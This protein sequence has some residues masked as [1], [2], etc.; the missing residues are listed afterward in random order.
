MKIMQ[1]NCV[2]RVG[3]TGKIVYDIHN[4]LCDRGIESVVCYGRGSAEFTSENGVYKTCS[5]HYADVNHLLARVSGVMY[6]GCT[7]STKKLINIIKKEKPDIVH[8]HCINGYFV[9][10][11]SI[12]RWLG[13]N[14]IKTLVTMHAEFF[15]TGG[16]GYTY[17]CEK[18][19][20]E[21]G[22]SSCPRY[23]SETESILFDR[24]STMWKRM[25]KA[26]SYFDEDNLIVTSVSPWLMGRGKQ[27][28]ILKDKKHET[29]LNGTDTE[30]VFVPS[31]FDELKNKLGVNDEKI[32]LHVTP[33][34]NTDPNH[35]KGG[36]YVTELAKKMAD[37]PVRFIVVGNC[38][39]S[40][41]GFPDNMTF[42]G[43]VSD[44]QTLAQY[45][46]MADVTLLTSKRE[47][48]SMICAESLACGT[49]VVGFE[50]GAPEGI[51]IKEYSDFVSYGDLEQLQNAV[52]KRLSQPKPDAIRNEA[53]VK[54][55]R[56]SMV[57]NYIKLYKSMI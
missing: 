37:K 31:E 7:F 39:E 47:T 11:Y 27:S 33:Y 53:K 6:G 17:E 30:N 21:S 14:K 4:G 12:L 20:N 49:P 50:A 8:L 23:K 5:E 45:Y 2:Y 51:S 42:V 35:N 32:I 40:T 46:S 19:Q 48:F 13:V 52:E 36:Y 24:T 26:F 15:Y 16:C 56:D 9:N 3:S 43:K 41:K 34:F 10:V 55:S 1:V 28:V 25:K 57:D 38:D 22:C 44:Q 29:V 18:W 54:Y